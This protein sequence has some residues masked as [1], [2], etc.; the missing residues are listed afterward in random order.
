[1]FQLYNSEKYL[2][3]LY[4]I[5]GFTS[6]LCTICMAVVWLHWRVVLNTCA[7]NFQSYASYYDERDCGCILYARDTLTY[8]VGSNVGYCYWATFGLVI[9]LVFCFGYGMYHVYRVCCK[10]PHRLPQHAKMQVRARSTEVMELNIEQE[11]REPHDDISPYYWTPASI[12]SILMLIYTLVHAIMLTDGFFS[13]C[14]QYRNRVVKYV[15]ATG[16][17]V[18]KNLVIELKLKNFGHCNRNY[19][20]LRFFK[21]FVISNNDKKFNLTN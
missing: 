7:G 11:E 19:L 13:T 4:S 17:M 16:Q 14:K 2:A 20:K 15:H 3:Y 10:S 8:F 12:I 21:D 5:A 1:M 6:L 9:P 18:R